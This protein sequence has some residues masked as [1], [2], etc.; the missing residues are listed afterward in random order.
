MIC[1]ECGLYFSQIRKPA[2]HAPEF[3][4]IDD[5]AYHRSVGSVRRRQ[6]R[7]VISLAQERIRGGAWLDIG[8]SF[9]YLLAEARQQ[10]FAVRGVEPDEKAIAA[11]DALLG[12]GV[13]ERGMMGEQTVPDGSQDVISMLDVLEH[14]PA[15]D[16]AGLAALIHAKL[17]PGGLWVIKVP[18]TEGAFF[19]V[20]HWLNRISRFGTGVM[21]DRL[22]QS[23]FEFP[24]TVF[25]RRSN[26]E[27]YLRGAGFEP[28]VCQ[29]PDEQPLTSMLDR[30]MMDHS[31]SLLQ[32]ILAVP[33]YAVMKL[34]DTLGRKSD[35][36]VVVA[37]RM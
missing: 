29:Y 36:L 8:C 5:A 14:I 15:D 12:P 11:A 1:R 25:F 32:A 19:N 7:L 20:A 21:I 13:V 10:G 26:L 37:R 16:L 9:G 35:S 24:H 17:K 18:T 28:L 34:A 33:P 31:V 6:A 2:L 30:L 4:R 27:R 3:S 22:W 23:E